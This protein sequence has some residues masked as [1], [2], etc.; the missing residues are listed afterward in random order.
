[1]TATVRFLALDASGAPGAPGATRLMVP[2]T[3]IFQQGK[4]AAVWKVG[5]DNTVTLQA[6]TVAAF[7]D[8]GALVVAGLNGGEQII[9]GGVNLLSAGEKV[10][11]VT[12]AI[13]VTPITSAAPAA[14][15]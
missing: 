1:M 7:T 13:P 11:V 8:S 2:L 10:R 6:I 14:T 5:A 15:Q 9:T 4:Q 12:P 3:A